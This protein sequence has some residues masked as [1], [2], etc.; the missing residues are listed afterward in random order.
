MAGKYSVLFSCWLSHPCM[1]ARYY[2]RRYLGWMPFQPCFGCS[3][4]YWGGW[5]GGGWQAV[6]QEYCSLEIELSE[7]AEAVKK[8]RA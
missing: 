2:W 7:F 5:P 3:R 8:G 6:Y 1:Y 4:W